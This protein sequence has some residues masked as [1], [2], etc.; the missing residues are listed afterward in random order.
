MNSMGFV[1]E[2]PCWEVGEEG[3]NVND[4]EGDTSRSVNGIVGGVYGVMK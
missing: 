1:E 4:G 2:P 3:A